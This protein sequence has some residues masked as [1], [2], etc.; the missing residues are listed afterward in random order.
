MAKT[1]NKWKIA[2][3]IQGH[4][5]YGWEDLTEEDS[6]KDAGVQLRCYNDNERGVSHRRIRRRVLND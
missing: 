5:G 4:Y 3:L 2:F 6:W 1:K